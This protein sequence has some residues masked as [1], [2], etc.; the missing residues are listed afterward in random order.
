MNNELKIKAMALFNFLS[1]H[2]EKNKRIG[3]LSVKDVLEIVEFLTA[4]GS[5]AKN[6]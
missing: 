4:G 6:Q 1:M 5:N 3:E 2:H